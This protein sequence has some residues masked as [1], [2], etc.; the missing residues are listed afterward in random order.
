M[1]KQIKL[2]FIVFFITTFS[3]LFSQ[4]INVSGVVS[5]NLGVPLPGVNIQVKN[6]SK[7]TSTNFDGEYQI[8]ANQGDILVFSFLGF[9]TKETSVDGASLNVTLKESSD[10][11]D[12]VVIT[13]FG[14]PQKERSLGY[15][16]TSIKAEDIDL[17][18][19]NDAMTSLQGRV[20]GLQISQTGSPGGGVDILIRGMSS[21]N[22]NQNNQP[23]IVIDGVSINNDTFSGDILPT[24]GSNATGSNEQFSFSS[25]VSDINPEDIE[26]YNVLKGAAATAL[27][28]V[29]A[30][31]GAIIITTKKGKLGKPKVSLS[32]TTTFSSV[33]QTPNLQST[34]REGRYGRPYRTYTPETN[35]GYTLT[36]IGSYNGPMTWGVRYSDDSFTYDG[37]TIDLS[38]DRF[39]SPYDLFDTGFTHNENISISGATDKFNYYASLGN[40][41]SEGVIPGTE[42]DRKSLRFTASYQASKS[43]K[44]TSSVNYSNSGSRK[45]TGGDKSV[46]S[47]LGWWSPTYPIND[48]L[49][50]DGSQ[51]NMFPGFIDN[52]RYNAYI[53]ALTE[54]TDRWIGNVNLNW[55]P[56]EWI[57]I[58]YTAQLDNYTNVI[59]RFVPAVLDAGSQVN[60]F[61][62]DQNYIFKGLESNLLVTFTH[63]FSEKFS[64]S[65]LLGNSIL[66][67][68]RSSYRMYGQ[69]LNLPFFNHIS[70]TQENHTIT[71]YVQQKRLVGFF[72]ELKLSYAD[73][74]FLS[75][76]GR[77]DLDSTLPEDNNSYFYPSISLAYDIQDIFGDNDILSFG[78][79]RASYAEV[80]NGTT[81]GQVGFFTYPD[82]NFPWAGT[83]GYVA[84]RYVGVPDLKPEKT[85]GYELGADLRFINNR[86]RLDYAYFKSKVYDA[87]FPVNMAPSAGII[88]FTRNAGTYETYGHE[89]LI[90]GDIIKNENFNWEMTYNFSTYDGLIVDLPEEIE[91]LNF[92]D[93][94]TGARIYLQPKE[95]D[96]IGTLYGYK[97]N[98]IDGE[99]LINDIGLP[100]T[101]FDEKVVVGDVTPDFTMSIGNILKWKGFNFNFLL[102]WKKGGDKYTWQ[103]Y[104][105]NRTGASQYTMQFRENGT[106]LF[107]G[108]MEDPSNPGTYIPNTTVAD[109]SPESTTGYQ[110]FNTTAYS[111]RNAEVLLQDASWVKLRNIGLSYEINGKLL[112]DLKIDGI[113]LSANASNILIWTPFDGFDPEGS[114]YSAGS[115]KYGFTGRGIPL[116]ENYSFGVKID[117]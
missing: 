114:D 105:T 10:N 61:I 86:I 32:A 91:F 20:A 34:F 104:Q 103:R 52:P 23:L 73:R 67:N 92:V 43:F 95:G 42:Y 2:S 59:N 83:G 102:E 44:I 38:N 77:Q 74:L 100:T 70:N 51:R 28:G 13:A 72:G 17:T 33:A 85:K 78:K 110:M 117:F 99:L 7:G 56:K 84:D 46:M 80:G 25:R 87:I 65:L 5:D 88:Q 53:S 113:T 64:S 16:V 69:N 9:E 90:S 18:G 54:D 55:N 111:R 31:N 48:F 58:N 27:Y 26:S 63:D 66:D 36:G 12:E 47:A 11:L 81:F 8:A 39:Y 40:N 82:P 101:N 50:P 112:S 30:A 115:N 14:I 21:M 45:A 4:N 116:T 68:K 75:I 29:R 57:N 107:D 41:A 35:L 98:R 37:T 49:N 19:Q 106:Y 15:S 96:K 3:L 6:T 79:L 1:K 108:V 109:F 60:G 97:Y 24:A 76:T 71:N 94:V 89:L 22:P 93:D 62:V